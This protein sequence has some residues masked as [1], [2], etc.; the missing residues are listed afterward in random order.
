MNFS[1]GTSP[2]LVTAESI[3][4]NGTP[5]LVVGFSSQKRIAI[6]R[7]NLTLPTHNSEC[8]YSHFKGIW[9]PMEPQVILILSPL[10]KG[11]SCVCEARHFE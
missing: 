5:L 3:G 11:I 1:P 8:L 9:S 2:Y 6:G 10:H 7:M 4:G